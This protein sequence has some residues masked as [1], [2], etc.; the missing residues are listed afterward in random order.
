MSNDRVLRKICGI[1]RQEVIGDIWAGKMKTFT[2][3][4]VLCT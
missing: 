4:R 2:L 1:K 3:E